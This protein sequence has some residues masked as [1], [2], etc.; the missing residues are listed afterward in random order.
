MQLKSAFQVPYSHS[1][2]VCAY[3]EGSR[4]RGL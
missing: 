4:V 1:R 3:F 2:I